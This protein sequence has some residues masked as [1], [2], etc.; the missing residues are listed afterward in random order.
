MNKLVL[1]NQTDIAIGNFTLTKTGMRITGNPSYQE[2][3]K[4][5]I[6]IQSA[7]TASTLWLGDW[8]NYGESR[9]GEKYSQ[10]IEETGLDYQSLR[11]AAYVSRQVALEDRRPELSYSHHAEVAALTPE[12]QKIM[13]DKATENGWSKQLLRLKVKQLRRLNGYN[14]L[15]KLLLDNDSVT[16]I[17]DDFDTLRS[18][19]GTFQMILWQMNSELHNDFGIVQNLF[20]NC[21]NFLDDSGILVIFTAPGA[22]APVV[23]TCATIDSPVWLCVVHKN[24]E[25]VLERNVQNLFT[26]ALIYR[27]TPKRSFVNTVKDISTQR[28]LVESLAVEADRVLVYRPEDSFLPQMLA[29]KEIVL[30]EPSLKYYLLLKGEVDKSE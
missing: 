25:I 30:L 15:D 11:N 14:G 12:E 27:K 10:A 1:R 28:T 2:W 6:F 29:K 4:V 8:I 3:A 13:L 5:G 22:L 23:Q 9:F 7:S 16:L 20:R 26:S 18:Q 24:S 21:Y 17:N 19:I